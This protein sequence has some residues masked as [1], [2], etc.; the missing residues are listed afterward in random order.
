MRC[1]YCASLENA[2]KDSRPSE[3]HSAI[4]RRRSCNACGGRFTTYE[5]IQ[6]RD[7]YVVKRDGNREEL[8]RAKLE[9]SVRVALRKRP[10]PSERVDQ[11]VT[12]IVRRLEGLNKDEIDT[13]T[14]G[15]TIMEALADLDH[16]AFIRFA[17]VYKDFQSTEDFEKFLRKITDASENGGAKPA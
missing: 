9:R 2:V 16:V 14:I 17:S 15:E 1:P 6:L 7:I 12:G 11:M 4:R 10:V 8:D 5:R 3:D 13:E